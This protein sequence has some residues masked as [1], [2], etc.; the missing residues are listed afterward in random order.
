MSNDD[1]THENFDFRGF[2]VPDLKAV[3][4]ASSSDGDQSKQP[5]TKHE[6]ASKNRKHGKK[7][8]KSDARSKKRAGAGKTSESFDDYEDYEEREAVSKADKKVSKDRPG[9]F[10]PMTLREVTVRNRIW[11][12]PMCTYSSFARDGRPTP[13]HYQHYVSRAFGGFGMVI[14]ESTAVAPE[15]RITPCDLGLWEDGQIDAWRWIVDGIREA[16]AVPAIQLNH[17]GRKASTG[18]FAVGYD[19][20]SV[21]EEAGGWPTMAPSEIAFGGLRT[22]RALSV[23]EI[24]GLVGAFAA[25]AGRAVAAGF[26]AI[27]IHAAHGYLISQ[28]LDPLSNERDD[29]YGGDLTGRSRFLV[30]VVDAVR[31]AVPEGVPVLVR[32]SATDWAAGGWDLDQTIALSKVLKEHGVDVMDVSTGGIM[33]G[34]SIPVKPNYQVPFSE[35]VKAKADIPVTAVGLITKPKQAAKILAHGE[36][37]AVEIGRAAL[38]DPYW[39]LRAANK[40]GIPSTEIPY[41]PQ[42]VAGAVLL[43]I[44]DG[45]PLHIVLGQHIEQFLVLAP[46]LV[47]RHLDQRG[48]RAVD[49]VERR[50]QTVER[51]RSRG[52][53][54]ADVRVRA[55]D[56]DLHHRGAAGGAAH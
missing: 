43:Q 27:Q 39:P 26:Q 38:R 3:T 23:D 55:G 21:P 15:G 48:L 16:G 46:R 33:S 51:F 10:A 12:P 52:E 4:L 24:H 5:K 7:K 29:E 6:D 8:S 25:A 2:D 13:F 32:I 19:G 11:L 35:Q 56:V 22:P 50:K 53:R 34:V 28:F 47:Q 42:Y 44:G 17:A 31:G 45:Q 41:A 37:D 30:E 1:L 9:L 36:A 18:C 14:V 20:Q 54:F 40:L 49:L